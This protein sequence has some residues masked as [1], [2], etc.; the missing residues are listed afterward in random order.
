MGLTDWK[1]EEPTLTND[2]IFGAKGAENLVKGQFWAKK[3]PICG[4]LRH[5]RRHKK[6][7]R[8]LSPPPN[9]Q[10]D[11]IGHLGQTTLGQRKVEEVGWG[12]ERF[13]RGPI[14]KISWIFKN[15][16][17]FK[18]LKLSKKKL[19]IKLLKISKIS[20]IFII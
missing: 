1:R 19:K 2:R 15:F 12:S 14:S 16:K 5:K 4:L 6:I 20:K 18:I 7:D 10:S 13:R 17:W 3:L 9:A 11:N 8:Q